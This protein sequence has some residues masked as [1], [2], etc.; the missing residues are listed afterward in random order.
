MAKCETYNICG[1]VEC[2]YYFDVKATSKKEAEELAR[3]QLM[4]NYLTMECECSEL[5]IESVSKE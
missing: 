3:Q 2:T 1:K 4:G 5:N